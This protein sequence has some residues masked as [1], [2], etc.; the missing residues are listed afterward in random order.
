MREL[1]RNCG[2]ED[3]HNYL[4]RAYLCCYCKVAKNNQGDK[5]NDE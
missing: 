1:M 4:Y 2:G 3:H 5:E